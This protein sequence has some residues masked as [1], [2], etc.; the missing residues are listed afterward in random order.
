MTTFVRSSLGLLILG[1]AL[2]QGPVATSQ[3]GPKPG[4]WI[5]LFNGKDLEGWTPKIKGY[6]A[7]EN[8]A[9]TF[10]VEDGLLKVAY[11]KYPKFDGKFGHLVSKRKYSHYRLRVEYRFVGDQC[12]GGPGWAL[13]NSG[14]MIH[15]QSAE[16]MRKDQEFP[17]SIEVQFLGGNGKDA[18]P[19]ANVCSPGTH[20]V[21][22]GKLIKTHC[23]DSKSKTYHG[24]QWVTVEVEV[25]GKGAIRHLVD[26]QPVLEYEQPQYDDTDADARTLMQGGDPLIGE[27]TISLQAESHPIEF[28][29]VELLPL[30]P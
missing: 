23:I 1:S 7:G 28:R 20:I 10:R 9:D 14:A 27:G 17:V 6:P 25:H 3:D 30:N 2:M 15:G 16:S 21:M 13:R 12:P 22:G 26:G 5:S 19:T 4:E 8:Y 24:D 18:R 11:D 29:K